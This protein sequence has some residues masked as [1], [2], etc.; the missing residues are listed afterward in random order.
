MGLEPDQLVDVV[1]GREPAET[2]CLVLLDP[3]AA[4]SSVLP[5]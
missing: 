2:P 4:R 5:V 1:P 3:S